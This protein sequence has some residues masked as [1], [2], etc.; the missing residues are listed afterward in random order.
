[1]DGCVHGSYFVRLHFLLHDRGCH[2]LIDLFA[3]LYIHYT[4]SQS[5]VMEM[6]QNNRIIC[7]VEALLA[8]N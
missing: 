2:V 4:R 1:M 3:A 5:A 7:F 6:Q 8:L